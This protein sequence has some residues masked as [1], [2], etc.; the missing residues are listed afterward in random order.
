[1]GWMLVVMRRPR[2]QGYFL[3]VG[4]SLVRWISQAFRDLR[5]HNEVNQHL[6]RYNYNDGRRKPLKVTDECDDTYSVL[7]ES[8]K[9]KINLCDLEDTSYVY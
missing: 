7:W 3:L 1:M 9:C 2:Y 6:T 4:E 8:L 5:V